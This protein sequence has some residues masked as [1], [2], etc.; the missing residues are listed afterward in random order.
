MEL[1]DTITVR[2]QGDERLVMLFVGNL[3][4]MPEREAVDLLVVSAF[5][6]GYVVTRT[7]QHAER[8]PSRK[9]RSEAVSAGVAPPLP[10]RPGSYP[11]LR[12]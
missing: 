4:R 1:I 3:T 11:R 9:S 7:S 2:H 10:A 6:D 5:P 8:S 12:A